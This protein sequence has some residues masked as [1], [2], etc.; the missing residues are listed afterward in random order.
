M[1][2]AGLECGECR[3]LSELSDGYEE[4]P[5]AILTTFMYVSLFNFFYLLTVLSLCWCVDHPPVA[6]HGLLI[7]AAAFGEHRL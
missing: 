2:W 5:C 7:A 4:V 1:L 3:S 6:A